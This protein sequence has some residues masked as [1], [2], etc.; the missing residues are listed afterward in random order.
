MT[1][2][3]NSSEKRLRAWWRILLFI[4]I[5]GSLTWAVAMTIIQQLS[6]F[7]RSVFTN[8]WIMLAILGTMVLSAYFLDKRPWKDYGISF[9]WKEFF[10]GMLIALLLMGS[11]IGIQFALGWLELQDRYYVS[12]TGTPFIL[13][14]IGQMFRYLC[15]S[16]FEEAFSRAYLLINL[17]EGL[18]SKK[19]SF[20]QAT[21][22]AYLITS[23]LF[24]IL[25]A[26]NPNATFLSILNLILIG[27]LL[28][29]M[30]LYTGRLSFSIGL[31][32]VWNILQNNMAGFANSGKAPNV[33]L[34]V[35]NNTGP[36]I[37]TGGEFGPEGGLICTIFTIVGILILGF[38]HFKQRG[39]LKPL[40]STTYPI[41][42]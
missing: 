4:G 19:V 3:W 27:L 38:W 29:L 12:F 24:G 34:F 9:N 2:F 42:T 28:G 7:Y 39:T 33:S 32:A 10:S 35:F 40:I 15:G 5:V 31:H 6:P 36:E 17:I 26:F 8:F 25:H 41:G 1:L 20:Q 30:V 16:I 11:I 22:L 13:V 37:W 18:S 14:F 23:A 21:W